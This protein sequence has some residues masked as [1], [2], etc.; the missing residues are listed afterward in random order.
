MGKVQNWLGK[1]LPYLLLIPAFGLITIIHIIPSLYSVYY[2]FTKYNINI[3]TLDHP[4]WAGLFEYIFLFTKDPF[5]I[6]TIRTTIE[7]SVGILVASYCFSLLVALLLNQPNLRGRA[8]YRVFFMLSFAVPI[9]AIWPIWLGIT[10]GTYGLI[11]GY[12]QYFHLQNPAKPIVFFETYPL[13]TLI[14]I[15]VWSGFAFG[16]ITLLASLTSLPKQHYE[17]A[18]LDGADRVSVFRKIEWPHLMPLNVILWMLGIV[19]AL[20]SFN[21]FYVLTDGG[22]AFE[23]TTLYIYAYNQLATGNI[24]YSAT[25][26]TILFMVEIVIAVFYVRYAWMAR[27]QGQ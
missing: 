22:P 1:R 2:S 19:S 27:G 20:N 7:W 6:Q 13:E 5:W 17:A 24:A 12:L 11:D 3:G 21:L 26:A 8:F 4:K 14:F 10:S 15:G 18:A 9:T 16:T 25:I 23:T